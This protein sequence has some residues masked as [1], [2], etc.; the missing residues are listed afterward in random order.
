[1]SDTFTYE[2]ILAAEPEVVQFFIEDWEKY[3]LRATM[4]QAELDKTEEKWV[5]VAKAL[6]AKY[7]VDGS[8]P[9]WSLWNYWCVK[10]GREKT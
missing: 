6:C 8:D 10:T 7:R 3:K 9:A 5:D 4:A 2:F 1:M